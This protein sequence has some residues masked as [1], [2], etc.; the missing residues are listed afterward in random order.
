M[1]AEDPSQDA[2]WMAQYAVGRCSQAVWNKIMRSSSSPQRMDDRMLDEMM[3]RQNALG[4][5]NR[6]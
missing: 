6:R 3:E 1:L 4:I 5:I 2:S